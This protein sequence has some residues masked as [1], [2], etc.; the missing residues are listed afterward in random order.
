[1]PALHRPALRVQRFLLVEPG[2]RWGTSSSQ[3]HSKSGGA[4]LA[5]MKTTALPRV[6]IR[7][8]QKPFI[9]DARWAPPVTTGG[10]RWP[11]ERI[12]ETS[13]CRRAACTIVGATGGTVKI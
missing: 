8:R 3:A 5:G 11:N 6:D 10:T 13:P 2:G 12:V 1:M 4:D 7:R 9:L